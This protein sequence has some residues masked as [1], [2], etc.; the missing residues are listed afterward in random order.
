MK[1]HFYGN[2][3]TDWNNCNVLNVKFQKLF[4]L[5]DTEM[6]HF[7]TGRPVVKELDNDTQIMDHFADLSNGRLPPT[8][9]IDKRYQIVHII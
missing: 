6:T 8:V 1:V 5:T 4:W 3:T 7:N 9:K 2:T